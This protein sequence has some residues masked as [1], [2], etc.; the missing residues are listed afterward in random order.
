[1]LDVQIDRN[2]AD[3]VQQGRVC[4]ACG[5]GFGLGRLCLWRHARRQQVRLPQ[6]QR[7][8]DDLQAVVQHAAR[9]GVVVALGG[10]ELLDQLGVALQWGEVERGE[11]SAR[12]RCALPDVFQQ[13]LPARRRQQRCGRLRPHQPFRSFDGGCGRCAGGGWHPFALEQREHDEPRMTGCSGAP[14]GLFRIGP[15]PLAPFPCPFPALWP[16]SEA[17]G[18]RVAASRVPR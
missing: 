13:F 7:V 17:F 6:F 8:G 14:F 12:E 11:L 4:R 2:L 5:P 9:I 3:V 1:M 10:R 18:Y 15:F 16:L